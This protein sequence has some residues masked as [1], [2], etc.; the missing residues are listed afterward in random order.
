MRKIALF[1]LLI[2]S[3]C[4][5]EPNHLG[6][7]LLWPFSGIATAIDNGAYNQRR[8]QVELYVKTNHPAIL[9]DIDTSGGTHLEQAMILA[10]IAVT[11]RPARILQ[12]KGD[13]ALY[14]RN[15]DALIVALMVYGQ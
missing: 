4:S 5:Q 15:I 2:T 3:A 9:N 7:P 11:D 14:E 12:L 6:N 10:N 8:G 1:S 13:R